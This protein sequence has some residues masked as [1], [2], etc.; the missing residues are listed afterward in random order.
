MDP[1]F[2]YLTIASSS[3]SV[4][5]TFTSNIVS[6]FVSANRLGRVSS[7]ARA[8]FC[9]PIN[10]YLSSSPL[11]LSFSL[12]PLFLLPTPRQGRTHLFLS[13]VHAFIICIRIISSSLKNPSRAQRLSVPF[14]LGRRILR[15]PVFVM[16]KTAVLKIRYPLSLSV[17]LAALRAT[18]LSPSFSPSRSSDF[19][20]FA[21]P[22][23]FR[24]V[25]PFRSLFSPFG[26]VRSEESSLRV[27]G[28][29]RTDGYTGARAGS[30]RWSDRSIRDPLTEPWSS[31]TLYCRRDRGKSLPTREPRILVRTYPLLLRSC[32][33]LAL[34]VDE[35]SFSP[36][37]TKTPRAT[38]S[39][40]PRR[41]RRR[42]RRC[43]TSWV[44]W[45]ACLPACLPTYTYLSAT[46]GG[47]ASV[48]LDCLVVARRRAACYLPSRL[49]C[50]YSY[51][52]RA[53]TLA[54]FR[55]TF[56][57]D[58]EEFR[59]T[60]RDYTPRTSLVRPVARSLAHWTFAATTLL[61][62]VHDTL[63]AL[64]FP[65]LARAAVHADRRRLLQSSSLRCHFRPCHRVT[66]YMGRSTRIARESSS[67]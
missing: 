40:H 31:T 45:R 57:A 38:F 67:S 47:H 41:R 1:A 27:K 50:R 4:C 32:L 39:L 11:S 64:D 60:L 62:R 59:N 20:P 53:D 58:E 42:G 35:L 3:S 65:A 28:D 26:L 24:F 2:P 49:Y 7:C 8:N 66:V 44:R 56:Q 5:F 22:A 61:R 18:F 33:S 37:R 19:F 9:A 55:A 46:P 52:S 25:S 48:R 36:L 34:S 21:L 30:I 51:R 6:L 14:V 43:R 29:G 12:A 10:I 63:P 16:R 54:S 17:P 15:E 23:F 13:L